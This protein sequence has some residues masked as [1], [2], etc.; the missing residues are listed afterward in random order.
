MS[1]PETHR[2]LVVDDTPAIHDDFRKV[3]QP[4]DEAIDVLNGEAAALFGP[5][6]GRTAEPTLEFLID[7]AQQGREGAEL[8]RKSVDEGRPYA[9][10]FVDMR[11][12]PGWDGL[13]TVQQLWRIDPR[14]QVVICTAHSDH[15]WQKIH[16]VL[17]P[18]DSL[19]ILKKPFDHIEARQL[20]HALVRKWTLSR[21]NESRV[22]E[23][24]SLV[25][26]RTRELHQ[27]EL[28]FTRA[29][30]ANPHAQ[31]LIALDRFE[32]L[33]TNAAFNRQ[34]NLTAEELKGASPETLGRGMDPQRWMK[35]REAL[36][37]GREVDDH[38][39]VFEPHP[40]V[41]RDLRC[42]ARAVMIG[43]RLCSVW[44][45]R[46]VT[47][48]LRLEQQLRQAQKMDAVGQLAAGIAHDFN[49]LLAVI[50]TYVGVMLSRKS[51]DPADSAD[52]LQVRAAADRA[53]ALTRQLLLFSR[54]QAAILEPAEV[55]AALEE[56]RH[57]LARVLPERVALDWT[58]EPG[59]PRVLIDATNLE[60]A[61]MNLVINARDA[62]ADQGR[63]AV[64]IAATDIGAEAT[65]RHQK[66][67]E[68]R[69]VV[70]SVQDTGQGMS[71]DVLAH[72]FEP[73]FTTKEPGKGTGLG[74]S[75]VYG[76]ADQHGGWVEV[77]STPGL[78]TTF[79]IYLPAEE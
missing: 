12:P 44:L 52:L 78:G 8:V 32:V 34:F 6:A 13:E 21:A 4:A 66:A 77:A 63:V 67:R 42:S 30:E 51:Y 59:L 55:G 48:Q 22:L 50:N 7:S 14:L 39:V 37:A 24:D 46:D 26:E 36:L 49:N 69:F 5:E 28:R 10:A 1:A 19:I 60:Q 11:M 61:V 43:D 73:F 18:T 38:P 68:G 74:L 64:S 29:F 58:V 2:V 16:E 35:L 70:I 57:M 40:G 3:F 25:Q 53:A 72:I 20:A 76:I 47:E 71:A 65:Q 45:L 75:T 9:L 33:A 31:T 41:R 54:R 56:L 17:G 79:Q 62:I 15:S 27:A 23:L